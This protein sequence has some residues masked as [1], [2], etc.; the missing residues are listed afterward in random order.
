MGRD[1]SDER[2]L[3][4]AK[5]IRKLLLTVTVADPQQLDGKRKPVIYIGAF[6]EIYKVFY[7]IHGIVKLEKYPISKV[8]NPLNLGSQQFYKISEILR[9]IHVV[10]KDTERNTSYL[11]DYID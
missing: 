8:E 9:R 1:E 4:G 7:E 3:W 10:P 2:N 6:V 11:N 5:I